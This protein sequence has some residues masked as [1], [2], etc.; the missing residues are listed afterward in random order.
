MR[1]ENSGS[2]ATMS[3][4][5]HEDC[6][7]ALPGERPVFGREASL[8]LM[9]LIAER[10]RVSTVYEVEPV[11]SSANR[12][13]EEGTVTMEY[14]ERNGDESG[15]VTV[16]CAIETTRTPEGWKLELLLLGSPRRFRSW[17]QPSRAR[18]V[19]TP[20]ACEA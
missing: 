11:E 7:Y 2:L 14:R 18:R 15:K 5:L 12:L 6:V 20:W 3:D 1:A 19:R 8:G 10:V 13:R 4:L 9:S 17:C 16:P